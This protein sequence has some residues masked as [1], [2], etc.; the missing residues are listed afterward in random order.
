MK[1]IRL[2]S[3]TL[4]L[5]LLWTGKATAGQLSDRIASFPKWDNK[6]TVQVATGDLVYPE[7]MAG[8][9]TVKST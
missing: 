1:R 2:L 8:T 4:I 6:P 7:W 9:W 5:F 3:L